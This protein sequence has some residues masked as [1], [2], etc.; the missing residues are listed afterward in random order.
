MMTGINAARAFL[1]TTPEPPRHNPIPRR[2]FAFS[3]LF[4]SAVAV[5]G[6]IVFI[7]HECLNARGH[8]VPRPGPRRYPPGYRRTP[9]PR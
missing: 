1:E 5:G 8:A 3:L 4:P 7:I 2:R 6:G 9:T